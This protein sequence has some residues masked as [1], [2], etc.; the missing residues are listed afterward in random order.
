V[1]KSS[2]M[3][4]SG[5]RSASKPWETWDSTMRYLIVRVAQTV[6]NAA[7]VWLAYVHR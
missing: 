5:H 4:P 3:Q 7:L 6:P 1:S 2:G